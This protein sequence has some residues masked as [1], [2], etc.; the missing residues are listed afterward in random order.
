MSDLL[1]K[2]LTQLDGP[3][4]DHT[5]LN[6]YY[7][8]QNPLTFLAPEIRTNLNNRLSRVSVN[9]PRVLVDTIAERLRVTGFT[10]D[11]W[12]DW[13]ANDLDQQAGVAHRE[14][15]IL[16]RAPVIVWG[17]ATGRPLVTVESASQVTVQR[18]PATRQIVAAV[19]RWSTETT[20][21]AVLFEPDQITR[22]TSKNLGAT[23]HGF[24]AV[25]TLPNPYGIVP[26]VELVNGGRVLSAGVSEMV[27]VLPITDA[28]TKLTTDM[29]VASEFTARPRRWATGIEANESDDG[30]VTNPF[31]ESNRMML[32]EQEGAKFGQLPGADL[33]GYKN[34][35]DVLMRQVSAVSG[36]PEHALGIG[37]DN[38]TSA[39]SIR[40]SEAALTAKAEARQKAF[41]K[42]WEEVAALMVATR[43]GADPTQVDV[44]VK[45]ADAS[46]RSQAAEADA[47]VKLVQAGIL[48][49]SA[50]LQKLGYTDDEISKIEAA[51]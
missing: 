9:I 29:L 51:R 39:D 24:E 21:E 3:T 7:A 41:G 6:N 28:V 36:L 50:A 13:I 22:Y 26:V 18:D 15:L 42:A 34:A 40:A 46:T 20:T 35:L 49:V 17:D 23:I 14:A 4:A 31:P 48:P 10:A 43:T 27:D 16:G 8:G 33:G 47:V 44:Q 2:L 32:A 37:G 1:Q 30:T 38:P 45:W 5:R 25:Q 19:K 11:V 12:P